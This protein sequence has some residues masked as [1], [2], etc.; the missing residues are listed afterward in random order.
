MSEHEFH[1]HGSEDR[2]FQR[3]L[4]L[5]EIKRY[6]LAIR[7]F[8][9]ALADDP[10][11]ARCQAYLA[12]CLVEEKKYKAAT[13]MAARAV[14]SDPDLGLAYYAQAVVARERKARKVALG[15]IKRALAVEPGNTSYLGLAAVLAADQRNY[16]EALKLSTAGLAIDSENSFCMNVRAMALIRL[17][18]SAPAKEAL[19]E[20]LRRN[21]QGALTLANLGWLSLRSGERQEALDLFSRSLA[22]DPEDEYARS[23]LMEALRSRY[24]LYS[25]VLRYFTWMG[26]RSEQAQYMVLAINYGLRQILDNVA[27]HNPRLRPWIKL[28]RK[29]VGY[30]AYLTWVARPVANL[31]LRFNAYGKR[32]LNKDEHEES[33]LVG[34]SLAGA[35]LCWG[36]RMLTGKRFWGLPNAVF[37]TMV[38]PIACTFRTDRGWRRNVMGA[39]TAALFAIGVAGVYAYWNSA[40]TGPA[41]S[42]FGVYGTGLL[43]SQYLS[44]LLNKIPDRD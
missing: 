25:L 33:S 23:G 18:E 35:L 36:L 26:D 5:Y 19:L 44:S 27:R 20:E 21:P 4:T 30:F 37:M 13:D 9:A 1:N 10:D 2:P 8:Q 40:L 38:I 31:L 24:P 28:F 15:S 32:L 11:N 34:M 16:K 29:I 3:G 14:A 12:L 41:R 22:E 7:E 43:A 42:L 17:G 6:D 39:F